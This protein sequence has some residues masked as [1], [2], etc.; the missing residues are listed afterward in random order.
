ML[1]RPQAEALNFITEVYRAFSAENEGTKS[2]DCWD[3]AKD[4]EEVTA[5]TLVFGVRVLLLLLLVAV[6][7]VV[8]AVFMMV[9]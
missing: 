3:E 2:P 5:W 9:G 7:G 8:L 1:K 4:L 6:V